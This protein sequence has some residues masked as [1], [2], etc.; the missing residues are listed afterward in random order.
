MESIIMNKQD[1]SLCTRIK[2]KDDYVYFADDLPVFLF[3][4]F[5][6]LMALSDKTN[7]V[8]LSLDSPADENK[9]WFGA[10]LIFST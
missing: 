10:S 8:E 9:S 4:H 6:T 5:L 1:Y 7:T 3:P 2:T